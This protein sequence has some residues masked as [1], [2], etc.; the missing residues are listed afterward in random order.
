[1]CA[2]RKRPV[3]ASGSGLGRGLQCGYCT[4]GMLIAARSERDPAQIRVVH[5]DSLSALASNSPVGSRMAIMLGGAAAG[6]ARN[7][8][9]KLIAIAAH[10]FQCAKE[11]IEYRDGTA[12]LK[13]VPGKAL[14]WQQLVEIVH[15][16]FHEL[17]PGMEP[18]LQA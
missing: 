16:K 3:A 6:A 15:R 14:A 12:G 1:R 8:K 5:A 13:G 2:R 4:P 10:S 18:G 11:D 7:I 9:E 17:P